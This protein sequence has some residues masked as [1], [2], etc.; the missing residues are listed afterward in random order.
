[1]HTYVFCSLKCSNSFRNGDYSLRSTKS[2]QARPQI[3]VFSFEVS[4]LEG[5]GIQQAGKTLE[6]QSGEPGEGSGG[7]AV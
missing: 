7:D 1:M 5:S 3:S 2:K 4:D 6:S